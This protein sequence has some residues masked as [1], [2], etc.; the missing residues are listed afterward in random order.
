MI[1]A[2]LLH[3]R[4]LP[5]SYERPLFAPDGTFYLPDFTVQAGGESWFWEHWG[6]MDQERYRNHAE[7]KRAWYERFLSGRLLETQESG[8]LS[9]EAAAVIDRLP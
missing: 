5:F 8:E 7:T 3:E 1:V 6:R 2:N 9:D 4:G